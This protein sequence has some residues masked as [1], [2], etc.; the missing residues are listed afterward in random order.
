MT[1][2]IWVFYK[3]TNS[4]PWGKRVYEVSNFGRVKLNGELYICRICKGYYYLGH[5]PLHRIVAELFIPDWDPTKQVDHID[6]NPPN[7]RVDN[8]RMAT[9]K[10]NA[11]NL[12][13]VE[14]HR[15][16]AAGRIMSDES[17]QKISEKNKGRIKTEEWRIN[18]S[19]R[20]SGINHPL[21]NKHHTEE[22]KQKIR[23]SLINYHKNNNN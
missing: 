10:E 11:N 22:T 2:E 7:N 6:G 21:Y 15:K 20:M 19:K 12:I 23:Q 9:A 8:L 14:R 3:E 18:H 4:R 13:T 17:K 1:K 5:R 16:A